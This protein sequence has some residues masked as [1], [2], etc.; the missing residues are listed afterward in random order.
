MMATSCLTCASI[1]LHLFYDTADLPVRNAA[2]TAQ[3]A[4]C[5]FPASEDNNGAKEN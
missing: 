5:I 1:E 3:L 4:D 2:K